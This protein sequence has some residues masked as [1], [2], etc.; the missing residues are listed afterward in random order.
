MKIKVVKLG[1]KDKHIFKRNTSKDEEMR[2]KK[3]D[4]NNNEANA[5]QKAG[6]RE[7][8]LSTR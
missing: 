5:Q 7:K 1:E 2:K 3:K 6:T 8:L 4:E